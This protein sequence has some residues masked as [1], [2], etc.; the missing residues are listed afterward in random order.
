[1]ATKNAV[2]LST[3]Q[4]LN[5]EV[6]VYGDFENP[7][8]LAKDVAEWIEHDNS[9]VMLRSIDDDEKILNIVYTIDGE[10]EAW[11]LTENGIYEVLMQNF[12]SKTKEIR[13]NVKNIITGMHRKAMF[14]KATK[15]MEDSII[16]ENWRKIPGFE[17]FYEVSSIGRVRSTV[18]S[19]IDKNGKKTSFP[20]KILRVGS[21]KTSPYLAVNLSMRNVATKY[22]VHRLVAMSFLSNW[23]SECE[24]NHIDGNVY[25]NCVCNLEMCTRKENYQHA[26]D[27][28]LK[29]DYGQFSS[30][31]KLSNIDVKRIRKLN[32]LGVAQRDL[33]I[34]F[35]VCKQ[36]ISSIVNFKIYRQCK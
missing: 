15:I 22:M 2:L 27:E 14:L 32:N 1:M 24:I 8:F 18:R 17:G 3:Q 36:T 28:K 23:D 11:M 4:I 35:D 13:K 31:A 33:A 7:L 5:Q 6:N 10:Q 21:G 26:I 29:K 34:A 16:Q 12:N 20:S 9:S 30:N 19:F 25:N